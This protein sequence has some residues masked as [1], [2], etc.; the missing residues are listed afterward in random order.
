VLH[1]Q[2]NRRWR[3]HRQ[4][5]TWRW[6]GRLPL[7]QSLIQRR[8]RRIRLVLFGGQFGVGLRTW[9]RYMEEGI[10]NPLA[11]LAIAR[12]LGTVDVGRRVRVVPTVC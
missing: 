7:W 8:Y 6:L 4:V 10:P 5:A 9:S 12:Q 11:H 1:R 2:L 3:R